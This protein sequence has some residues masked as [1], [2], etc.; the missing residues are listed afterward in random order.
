M[1]ALK[2]LFWFLN[3]MKDWSLHFGGPLGG[4]LGEALGESKLR[5]EGEGVLRCHVDS[6]YAGCPDEYKSTSG[7]VITVGGAVDL[8]SRNQKSTAQSTTDADY[9]AF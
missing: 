6:H 2:S 7:L 4:A 1:V 3:S 9:Y 8:R 5:G